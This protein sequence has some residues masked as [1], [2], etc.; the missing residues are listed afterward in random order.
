MD[1]E[2]ARL[3]EQLARAEDRIVEEQRR[4][5][6]EQC[7]RENAE[8]LARSSQPQD[9]TNY[10]EACHQLHQAIDVVTDRSLTTQ[11][12]TTNPSGRIYPRRIVPWDA[13]AARQE[14]FWNQL[15]SSPSLSS[16][17]LF[18]S[19]HQIEYVMSLISPISSEIGLRNFER[20]TVENAVQ[21]LVDEAYKDPALRNTL[22]LRGT[23]TFESHTNLGQDDTALSESFEQLSTSADSSRSTAS[24]SK[25][26]KRQPRRKARGKGHLADQF[27]IYRPDD[28]RNMPTLAIE[29]K[30]PH[31]LSQ[32]ELVTGLRSEIRP[33]QDIINKDGRGFEFASRSLAAAVITQLF[34]YMI[35]K[36]IQ[37]GYVCT[38]EAFVF[39][40]IPDDPSIVYYSV[41]LP[42]LDV[43]D[44]AQL[45]TWAVE[46][47]DVL[48]KI[49]ISDRKGPRSRD[50]TYKARPWPGFYRSPIKTRSGCK[51]TSQEG[52]RRQDDDD[53]RDPP[54]P[55][56]NRPALPAQKPSGTSA[57]R[58]REKQGRQGREK[59][60]HDEPVQTSIKNRPYC[61]HQC[62]LGLA[63]AGPID[64]NCPNA[65][66]HGE[67]HIAR[68]KFL[69][70]LRS[71]L[72]RDRGPDADCVP[73]YISGSLGSLFKVRLS[74]YGYTLVAKGM[75]SA[76]RLRLCHE[77]KIYDQI[78]DIQGKFTPVCL[79][80]LDLALP[81]YCDGGV[82]NHLML[83]SWGGRPLL[84]CVDQVDKQTVIAGVASAFAALHR[85]GVLHRDAEARNILFDAPTGRVMVVD[86]ERAEFRGREPLACL[87]A[88]S[89]NR[90]GSAKR[91]RSKCQTS[92][93]ENFS[94]LWGLCQRSWK[95]PLEETD[96]VH[97]RLGS[98]RSLVTMSAGEERN[99]S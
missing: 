50:H 25:S 93:E 23:V 71:Q 88:Q 35:G 82:Y 75:E 94:L 86:F 37:Y 84:G 59:A 56:P 1:D 85:L 24:R 29:Y 40:H 9:L 83:L 21:K 79:G 46:Y 16:K 53:N 11:G 5:E 57:A 30:A 78:R 99:S 43:M 28:G 49:P 8:L 60:R 42:C 39:L 91:P 96:L 2:V 41:C 89:Q 36:G 55:S 73:L 6:E 13:F 15:A 61:T 4:R 66:D 10:L 67:R 77:T 65:N 17:C 69:S 34:S 22:S 62:L 54:S 20:D 90:K 70:L 7:R 18:P 26:L 97:A 92:L 33:A 51:P 58:S 32:E 81:Q 80:L 27:C 48:S 76:D 12:D 68:S 72:A 63:S 31:K 52:G 19:P 38:G 47:E 3:R 44:A 14:E 74:S 45:D 64:K 95:V 87:T 98:T